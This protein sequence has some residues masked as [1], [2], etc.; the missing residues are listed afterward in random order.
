MKRC[1]FFMIFIYPADPVEKDFGFSS[2]YKFI[3]I[4]FC[5]FTVRSGTFRDGSELRQEYV[6]PT[7]LV[8]QLCVPLPFSPHPVLTA[9]FPA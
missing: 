8:A 4:L 1:H 3:C 6:L 5:K 7:E 9:S 2:S